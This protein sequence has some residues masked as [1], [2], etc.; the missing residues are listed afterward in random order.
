[1]VKN[2]ILEKDISCNSNQN[3]T[4]AVILWHKKDLKSK[5]AT[6]DK[7]IYY[8]LI[9]ESIYQENITIKNIYL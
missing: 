2:K 1:M 5:S 8:I 9:K 3:R 7:E 6:K 4:G